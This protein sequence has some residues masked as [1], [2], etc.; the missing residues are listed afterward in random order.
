MRFLVEDPVENKFDGNGS[1]YVI[2]P[3]ASGFTEAG[4][5]ASTLEM[6]GSPLVTGRKV[7]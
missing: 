4:L 5:T 1:S 7:Q 6:I 2:K 3:V